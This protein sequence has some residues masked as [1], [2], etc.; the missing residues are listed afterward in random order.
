MYLSYL[1]ASTLFFFIL[2]PLRVHHWGL[3]AV[4]KG[5]KA[6][7]L[8]HPLFTDMTR[9]HYLSTVPPLLLINLTNIGEAFHDQ[10]YPMEQV[11]ILPRLHK[12]FVDRPLNVL[13]FGS[14][15]IDNLK[16]SELPL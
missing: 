10:L 6:S 13:I 16:L 4:T 12:D 8:Q 2:N 1:R 7:T 14:G 15:P 9:Q 3:V 5:L 11:S